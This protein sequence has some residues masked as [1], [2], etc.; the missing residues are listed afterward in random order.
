MDRLYQL[1]F[2]YGNQHRKELCMQ[3]GSIY[4]HLTSS[5]DKQMKT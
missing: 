2:K 4:I 3:D 5:L 1:P